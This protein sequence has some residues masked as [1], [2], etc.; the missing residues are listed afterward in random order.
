MIGDPVRAG[1]FRPP[2]IPSNQPTPVDHECAPSTFG[3]AVTQAGVPTTR[4]V[5]GGTLDA[6]G[7]AWPPAGVSRAL[8]C[9]ALVTSE[10][11]TA[12]ASYA[13][14]L[15][16]GVPF[17]RGHGMA[18]HTW[19]DMVVQDFTGGPSTD[20]QRARRDG[21]PCLVVTGRS[22]PILV[23][24]SFYK[25]YVSGAAAHLG[26][27][28]EHEQSEGER[29]VQ[30][31]ERGTLA[32]T[33]AGGVVNEGQEQAPFAVP[34]P[35]IAVLVAA[36]NLALMPSCIAPQ[37]LS[38]PSPPST[39]P[40]L[41]SALALPPVAA[42]PPLATSL[43]SL[44]LAPR[45]HGPSCPGYVSTT[46]V[47]HRALGRPLVLDDYPK[48][49]RV[50]VDT[51]P[52][53]LADDND[54]AFTLDLMQRTGAR[55]ALLVVPFPQ[56]VDLRP[57]DKAFIKAAKQRGMTV[58]FRLGFTF[59]PGNNDVD[60]AALT[61][62]TQ[63]LTEALGE[64]P[65]IQLGNEPNLQSE[66]AEGAPQPTAFAAWWSRYAPA[67]AQGGGYPGFPGLAADH[68]D[69]PDGSAREEFAF[70]QQTLEAIHA[71]NP[72]SLDRAWTGAHPSHSFAD[73]GHE[74][75]VDD[76]NWQLGRYDQLV[77]GRSLP[78]IVTESGYPDGKN[79]R[80]LDTGTA[81]QAADV[82]RYK[83]VL[84][85][86]PAWLFVGTADWLLTDRYGESWKSIYRPH[87]EASA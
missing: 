14:T 32:W 6:T 69:I 73:H 84:A 26:A 24:N 55:N 25:A 63:Q 50:G 61:R 86:R 57:V 22:G 18:A 5:G 65:Y 36:P 42:P 12:I 20:P 66:W 38:A 78:V 9:G 34:A 4:Q 56:P 39:A 41:I 71:V 1:A 43:A 15:S 87:V 70:Y 83:T 76:V 27:P 81:N 17:D 31:F 49:H 72:T 19:N 85:N 33:P 58:Q 10:V 54:I 75:Y 13:K 30:R 60:P 47:R 46:P 37:L 48:T 68:C 62:Y 28:L 82:A 23:G 51:T 59:K 3:D 16:I 53:Y 29:V 11:A 44:V 40:I 52:N 2:S 21:G 77:L 64:G 45:L 35:G 8:P 79:S 7:T 80:R 74:D 67:V